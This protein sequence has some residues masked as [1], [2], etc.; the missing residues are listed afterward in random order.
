M[1]YS[2][3]I[4]LF[5][6]AGSLL[7][8][9]CEKNFLDVNNNPNEPSTGDINSV[10]S[11]ALSTSV[12]IV[13]V[14]YG[15]LF[16]PM[17]Y[18]SFSNGFQVIY[19]ISRNQ[20]TS[21]DFTNVWT[22]CYQNTHDYNYV[23]TN[24][25]AKSQWFLVAAAKTMMTLDFQMLVDSYNDVPYSQALHLNENGGIST[26][27]Y[28]KARTIYNSLIT[29]LD[30]AVLLFENQTLMA[31]YNPGTAD[32]MFGGS[33]AK[34]IK[35]TNTLKLRLL[36]HESEIAAQE[37]NFL[38][39]FQKLANDP[40][41]FLGAGETAFVNP[42]YAAD[43]DAHLNPVWGNFG[44]TLTNALNNADETANSYF[45]SKLS[46]LKD[47]RKGFFCNTNANGGI[48]GN[49][50]GTPDNSNP[51]FIGGPI[52]LDNTSNN[53]PYNFTL[54]ATDVAP[55]QWGILQNPAQPA[56]LLSS[57]ESLFLQAEATLNGWLPGGNSAAK[58]LYQQAITDNFIYLNV[59]TDGK[60]FNSSPAY[61]AQKY[62]TQNIPNVNWE[63]SSSNYLQAIITQKYLSL[64]LTNVLEAWTDFRRTGYP[65][66][67]PVSNDPARQYNY[68]YRFI[69]PQN[70]YDTNAENVNAEGTV[71]MI[72]PKIF[73]MP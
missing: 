38:P 12:N 21:N 10:F 35:F 47:T 26:P 36:I 40:N 28:D 51:S 66:D 41:G 8:T 69:Y 42:G 23:E 11:N 50:F 24:A 61:W 16:F 31:D 39:E 3:K 2:I 7:I 9:A 52:N 57:W 4:L 60:N 34:W 63:A 64:F 25:V 30:S 59:F 20:Y 71:T 5:F 22:D 54:P 44:Y 33:V 70:E 43:A 27:A 18:I 53:L 72:S 62:Y 19:S 55:A 58:T 1:K 29:Q 46:S 37:S 68:I 65:A 17:N 73:W 15:T 6:F 48:S 14:D 67:L 45:I 56:I 49:P 32:I 13:N